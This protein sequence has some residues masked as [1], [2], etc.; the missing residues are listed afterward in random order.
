MRGEPT[1]P[2][3]PSP[4]A[5]DGGAPDPVRLDLPPPSPGPVRSVYVHA[6]FCARRCF[7]CDF[8]VTVSRQGDAGAWLTALSG[9]LRGLED[10]GTFAPATFLETLFVGGGTPSLLGAG[11]MGQLAGILGP[12][13]L[14]SPGLEWTVEANP[15]SFT[16]EVARAWA[17]SGVNRVSLGAQSFQPS[18]LKWMGRLHGP[19][20]TGEAVAA[21]REAGLGNVSLDL[22]FGLP[23][24]VERD[25]DEDLDE[26]LGQEVPHL[27]LYGLSVEA[28]TPLGRGVAEGRVLPTGEERYREEFLRAAERLAAAG[29]RHYEVSNFALP[30]FESA[31]NRVYWELRPYVGLG[32][33]AHSFRLPLRRW[34]LRDWGAYQRAIL[35]GA[36]PVGGV[37]ELSP[38]DIR[39]ERIWL[40]LRTL[41]GISRRG[42]PA[43]ALTLLEQWVKEGF[44]LPRRDGVHLTPEGWLLLDHLAVELDLALGTDL[45]GEFGGRAG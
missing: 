37:E 27:S 8:A 26:A 1:S 43:P 12:S 18:V 33:S 38:G 6:P 44:A 30:G 36:S 3:G 16:Q 17:R 42:L 22:I 13:R 23:S 31:H 9:E 45:V 28:G 24:G 35:Q 25:W 7:Y 32:S 21:A 39:L 14:A 10:E 5:Q 40:G 4:G 41:Q 19:D 34:N 15:E 29:Y 2:L 20:R 11:A